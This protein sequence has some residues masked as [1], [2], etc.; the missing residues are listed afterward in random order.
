M[1]SS[2]SSRES[3]G[4]LMHTLQS[5]ADENLNNNYSADWADTYRNCGSAN[6]TGSPNGLFFPTAG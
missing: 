1:T 4:S 6:F 3:S 5:M 2:N